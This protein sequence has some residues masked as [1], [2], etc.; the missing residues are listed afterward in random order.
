[1]G[2]YFGITMQSRHYLYTTF[3]GL[4]VLLFMV[5]C[6]GQGIWYAAGIYVVIIMCASLLNAVVVGALI[7][8]SAAMALV[9]SLA[10][11]YLP[12][13]LPTGYGYDPVI[14]RFCVV[15][16]GIAF[17]ALCAVRIADVVIRRRMLR[18]LDNDLMIYLRSHEE[19][20]ANNDDLRHKD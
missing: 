15:L 2:E 11:F 17:A 1:M 9:P 3:C 14:S 13:L 18:K 19:Q 5:L 6:V 4:T 8:R 10:M 12:A 20:A 16:V 7:F